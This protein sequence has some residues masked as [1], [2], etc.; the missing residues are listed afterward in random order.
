[1]DDLVEAETLVSENNCLLLLQCG[2][3]NGESTQRQELEDNHQSTF[4]W[5]G[6]Q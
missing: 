6:M 1:M 5:L 3:P 4:G 2:M